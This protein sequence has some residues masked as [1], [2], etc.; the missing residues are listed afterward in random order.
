MNNMRANK[1]AALRID[2]YLDFSLDSALIFITTAFPSKIYMAK[3]ILPKN[4]S[5]LNN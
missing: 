4:P 1:T 2:G 3:P 5:T